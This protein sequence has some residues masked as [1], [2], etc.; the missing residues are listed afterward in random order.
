MNG[1]GDSKPLCFKHFF[2]RFAGDHVPRVG[3]EAAVRIAPVYDKRIAAFAKYPADLCHQL[4]LM[5]KRKE[6]VRGDSH[7][8]CA[9]RQMRAAHDL[10]IALEN[11]Y[12]FKPFALGQGLKTW[13]KLP[14]GVY[15]PHYPSLAYR[16]GRRTGKKPGSC[17]EVGYVHAFVYPRRSDN[18]RRV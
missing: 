4:V 8:E 1:L 18:A 6:D 3:T 16:A 15:G 13:Q 17:A 5:L 7:I 12:I 9:F 11:F 14:L 10:D 2:S